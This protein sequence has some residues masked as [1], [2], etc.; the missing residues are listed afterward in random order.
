MGF[1]SFM[2]VY[3]WFCSRFGRE[4]DAPIMRFKEY[5][6]G[7]LANTPEPLTPQA[8][9]EVRYRAFNDICNT[10][11]A[12]NIFAQYVY[13]VLPTCSHL[14]EFR[15]RFATQLGLSSVISH[16]L[17]VGGRSPNKI[18]FSRSSGAIFNSDFYPLF[19]SNGNGECSEPV[20]F[21]MSRN[22]QVLLTPFCLEGIFVTT[23]ASCAQAMNDERA[24]IVPHLS[25]FFRDELLNWSWRRLRSP[26]PNPM[27]LKA[28]VK[29]NV[30]AVSAR[31]LRCS[32]QEQLVKNG[33]STQHLHKGAYDLVERA[34][35]PENLCRLDSTWHPWL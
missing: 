26:G 14:W 6:S 18:V 16:A 8:V 10:T 27:D 9:L 22:I 20:P 30:S 35:N 24:L 12:D 2:E 5:V 11:V 21:R 28:M 34:V 15:K 17:Q 7:A 29:A 23:I 31:F 13:K 3:E 19:D 4:P 32:P 33:V 25:I 1:I